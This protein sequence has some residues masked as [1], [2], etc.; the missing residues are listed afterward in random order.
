MGRHAGR[1]ARLRAHGAGAPDLD[2]LLAGWRRLP[3]GWAAV[4][5]TGDLADARGVVIRG[6]GDAP[7]G[8]AARAHARRRE[9][10]QAVTDIDA[11]FAEAQQAAHTAAEALRASR[12]EHLAA[13]DTHDGLERAARVARESRVA[14]DAA[15]E[16][17]KERVDALDGDL[18]TLRAGSPTPDS[19][20]EGDVEPNALAARQA[21]ADQ[22]RSRRDALAARRDES[23][24]AWTSTRRAAEEVETR[25]A[26]MRS[27]RAASEARVAAASHHPGTPHG[28]RSDRCRASRP[29]RPA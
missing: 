29:C 2:A 20:V 9:L 26:G 7:G 19:A 25:T 22:A 12:A 15:V 13:R 1:S 11:R 23:R 6:R 10:G 24:D 17:G 8:A 4:T 14:A 27:G 5:A 16:R 21:A 28:D 3:P 18:A